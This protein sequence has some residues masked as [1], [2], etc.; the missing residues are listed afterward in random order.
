MMAMPD[1]SRVCCGSQ[2]GKK[3]LILL[4]VQELLPRIPRTCTKFPRTMEDIRD[5]DM[6]ITHHYGYSIIPSRI[7]PIRFRQEN[8]KPIDRNPGICRRCTP[9][10][11]EYAVM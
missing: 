2:I 4:D 1:V 6:I 7:C 8:V 5:V 10:T 9:N 3:A 11:M